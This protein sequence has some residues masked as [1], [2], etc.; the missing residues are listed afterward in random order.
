MR[1]GAAGSSS[2]VSASRITPGMAS[3]ATLPELKAPA[4]PYEQPRPGSSPSISVTLAPRRRRCQA[5]QTPTT[6]A[7]TTT[8]A[9]CVAGLLFGLL[10]TSV[11]G[12]AGLFGHLRPLGDL[13]RQPFCKLFRRAADRIGTLSRDAFT[14]V[15]GI[16]HA[17]DLAV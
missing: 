13:A 1:K 6:P 5:V 9:S 17:H 10:A 2:M 11:R 3:G 8:T 14:H 15:G 16:E 12:H 4:L 7:P